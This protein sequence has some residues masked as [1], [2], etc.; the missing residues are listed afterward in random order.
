MVA[1]PFTDVDVQALADAGLTSELNSQA[2]AGA[3]VIRDR[4]KTEPI[5][6]VWLVPGTVGDPAAGLSRADRGGP[7]HRRPGGGG[8]RLRASPSARVPQEP[9]RLGESG[10]VAMV[11]DRALATRLTGQEGSARGP[12]VRGRAGDH[13]VGGPGR[14]SGCGGAVPADADIDPAVLSRALQD[15]ADP[16]AAAAIRPVS[17]SD[18][19]A[20]VPALD[21][22]ER[23][24]A[25]LAPTP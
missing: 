18:L 12:A 7:G 17:A 21:G 14:R 9:V 20:R 4:L 19:F 8:T 5:P 24:V 25:T 11:N 3:Q 13:V 1:R 10:T 6:G 2:E 23:P 22:G 16:V 15:L